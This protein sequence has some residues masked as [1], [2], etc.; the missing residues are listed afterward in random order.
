MNW[1][2]TF[3]LAGSVLGAYANL[4]GGRAQSQ[5]YL[6]Q[7]GAME[8][9]AEVTR[10]MGRQALEGSTLRQLA[11]RRTQRQFQGRQRASLAQAGIGTRGSAAAVVA[12]D[13]ALAEMDQLNLAQ[14]GQSRFL[15]ALT[16]ADFEDINAGLYRSGASSAIRSSQVAATRSL[17][18][19]VASI[20]GKGK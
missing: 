6:M 18:S 8:Y 17:L 12:Q 20:Y 5:Q 2:E 11:L 9:N 10:F 19:G 14:E 1:A 16:Q 13:A 7:A 15:A 4:S 3:Q